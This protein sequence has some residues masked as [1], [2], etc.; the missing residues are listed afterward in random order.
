LEACADEAQERLAKCLLEMTIRSMHGHVMRPFLPIALARKGK[1]ISAVTTTAVEVGE[2]VVPLFFRRTRSMVMENEPG[3]RHPKGVTCDVQWRSTPNAVDLSKGLEGKDVKVKVFI[4][5]ELK[6]PKARPIDLDW[7]K[8]EEVHPFWFIKRSCKEE[9]VKNMELIFD[10][11]QHIIS[12]PFKNVNAKLKMIAVFPQTDTYY[13]SYPCLV[14]TQPILAG[15]ELILNWKATKP[16]KNGTD[17]KD[18]P[19]KNAFDQIAHADKKVRKAKA[20]AT[21]SKAVP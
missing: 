7:T 11:V 6:L 19:R 14:N 1:E 4:S 9:D 20:K 17:D 3:V 5:P 12:A 2:L 18:A 13:M 15:H 21:A 10:S 8:T 16:D